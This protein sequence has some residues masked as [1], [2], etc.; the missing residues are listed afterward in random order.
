LFLFSLVIAA[1]LACPRSCAAQVAPSPPET[2]VLL[3]LAKF[4]DM[5]FVVYPIMTADHE[6]A[7]FDK[8]IL[9]DPIKA[10]L[11]LNC[12]PVQIFENPFFLLGATP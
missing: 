10:E 8:A 2:I 1:G 11:E 4:P 12:K 6:G 3:N 5:I 7:Q 9:V